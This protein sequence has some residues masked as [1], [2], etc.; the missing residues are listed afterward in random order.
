MMNFKSYLILHYRFTATHYW[1]MNKDQSK[2]SLS[3]IPFKVKIVNSELLQHQYI[4]KFQKT[5]VMGEKSP[6]TIPSLL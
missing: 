4:S 3:N 6:V 2:M 5:I 1:D